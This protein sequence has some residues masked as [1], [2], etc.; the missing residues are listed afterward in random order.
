MEY[1]LPAN[2]QCAAEHHSTRTHGR[3]YA[4]LIRSPGRES[5]YCPYRVVR[6]G[7]ALREPQP[8]RSAASGGPC[9]DVRPSER[10]SSMSP[11]VVRATRISVETTLGCATC[12]WD[13]PPTGAIRGALRQA[14]HH[15]NVIRGQ[16]QPGSRAPQLDNCPRSLHGRTGSGPR[17]NQASARRQQVS[18]IRVSGG[19]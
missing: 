1:D 17:M 7:A 4:R 15:G 10:P 2:F 11:G 19:L 12:L 8:P 9:S 13:G 14:R 16:H 18:A 6:V 5:S 3:R